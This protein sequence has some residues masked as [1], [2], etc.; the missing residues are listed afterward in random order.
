M[1]QT[2]PA[3]K[4]RRLR[5]ALAER[6]NLL[7]DKAPNEVIETRIRDGVALQGATPWILM[8]AILVASIGLNV[9]STAVIIGAMLISPL[10]GPIMGVGH[11]VAVHD[12]TLVRSALTNLFISTVIGLVVSALYFMLTPLSEAQSELLARTSP[13]LWDVLVA[14][15]GGM[16]GIIG[17]TREEK[18]AV[19]P[20]VAIATALM[21][22]LCTAGYGVATG[23]WH[24]F[25]GAFYLYSINCVFIALSTFVGIRLLRFPYHDFVDARTE[26][27]VKYAMWLIALVTL[28][29]SVYLATALVKKELYRSRALQFVRN[30]FVFKDA[31]VVDAR[32]DVPSKKIDVSLIGTPIRQASVAAIEAKLAQAGLAGSRILLHQ[33]GEYEK[34]DVTALKSGILSDLYKQSR[35]ALARKEAEIQA[36]QSKL[37]TTEKVNAEAGDIA[38]E[39]RAQYPNIGEATISRGW[40]IDADG[41][42]RAV[43][44]L[45]IA[46]ADGLS[47]KDRERILAWFKARSKNSG[48]EVRF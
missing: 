3:P 33:A 21:P 37:A 11:G 12:F 13:T 15:F 23:Q 29:P 40:A 19:I 17:V 14:M 4:A 1:A 32:V 48:A 45:S 35:D 47:S 27:K 28:I 5:L 39:L 10:M 26:R 36:L 42:Q 2:A 30:E 7:A 16:A 24:F 38:A 6:F 20:G 43:E 46:K 8:F 44:L 22:P 34:V 18:S 41:T 25:G 31:Y 9:N